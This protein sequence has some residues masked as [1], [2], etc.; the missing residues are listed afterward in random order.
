MSC[1]N[2]FNGCTEI[3]S[4]KCI[5]YTGLDI[6]QLEI[7]NGD[8]LLVIENKIIEYLITTLNGEGIKPIIDPEIICNVVKEF[9]PQCGDVEDLEDCD[10]T[11]ININDVFSALIKS[12]CFLDT[13][14][15][16][17]SDKIDQFYKGYDVKCLEN[18]DDESEINNVLQAL[19]D[20]TCELKIDFE[21][22]ILELPATYVKLSDLNNLIR[23]YLE[24]EPVVNKIY[25]KMIPFVA[26]EYYGTLDVFDSTGRGT[27]DWEQVYL[28]N[29]RYGTPDKRG[30]VAV[31]TVNEMRGSTFN[32]SINPSFPGNPNYTLGMTTGSNTVAL[33]LDN[34]PPHTHSNTAVST[35]VDPGHRHTFPGVAQTG[36]SGSDIRGS[37]LQTLNTNF[38]TTGITVNTSVTINNSGG[39]AAHSNIQPVLACHYI[40]HIP[41]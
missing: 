13:S 16:S 31:G 41:N 4:D 29:G 9:L 5:K 20:L 1:T 3:K 34:I 21:E 27:G 11:E 24:S 7:E 39:G 2:C 40:M 28:C 8:S 10:I 18:V 36:S 17:V 15:K 12:L 14:L 37:V 33:T 35:V 23:V 25:T 19:I 6:P 26:V 38:S 30:R 22:I 32:P